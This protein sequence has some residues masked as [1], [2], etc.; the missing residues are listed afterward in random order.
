MFWK[1]QQQKYGTTPEA[2]TPYQ[3]AAQV[4]DDRIGSARVQAENWRLTALVAL[5]LAFV[6]SGAFIWR[7]TQSIITP[8]VVE[9]ETDG[10]VRTVQ[11]AVADYKPTDAQCP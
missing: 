7:S 4:W 9:L 10:R 5:A 8:Y 3:R 1:R 6:M 11:S 2:V